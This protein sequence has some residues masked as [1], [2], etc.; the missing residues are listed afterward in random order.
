MRRCLRRHLCMSW[1]FPAVYMHVEALGENC[2]FA[3]Q[4]VIVF[5]G[6]LTVKAILYNCYYCNYVIVVYFSYVIFI[7]I[8]ITVISIK[9]VLPYVFVFNHVSRE[10]GWFFFLVPLVHFVFLLVEFYCTFAIYYKIPWNYVFYYCIL[11]RM[12][13]AVGTSFSFV[14]ALLLCILTPLFL[15]TSSGSLSYFILAVPMR[16]C[17]GKHSCTNS[18]VPIAK[19]NGTCFFSTVP[20][21]HN[22]YL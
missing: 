19:L 18:T 14:L 16:E 6:A 11:N 7:S 4:S 12:I 13:W 3:E 20:Q 10:G 2:I 21:V 5:A 17:L 8:S 9:V 15:L 1:V 22:V